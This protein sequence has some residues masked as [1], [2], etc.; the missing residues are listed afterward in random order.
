MG[1]AWICVWYPDALIHGRIPQNDIAPYVEIV[2]FMKGIQCLGGWARPPA[3]HR[4]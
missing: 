3:D 2:P 1:L 4:L